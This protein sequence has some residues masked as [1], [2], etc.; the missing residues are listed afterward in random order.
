MQIVTLYQRFDNVDIPV[1]A[2][3]L[4]LDPVLAAIVAAIV[5]AFVTLVTGLVVAL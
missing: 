4:P 2:L 3:V 1:G 5:A